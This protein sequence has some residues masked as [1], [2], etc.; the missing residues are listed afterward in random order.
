MGI[1]PTNLLHAMQALY[2]LS[3]APVDQRDRSRPGASDGQGAE[4]VAGPCSPSPL[5]FSSPRVV[6]NDCAP[7]IASTA[8]R[9]ALG[10]SLRPCRGTGTG[11]RVRAKGR[12]G[13]AEHGSDIEHAA[14]G[15]VLEAACAKRHARSGVPVLAGQRRTRFCRKVGKMP[16][17]ATLSGR[18]LGDAWSRRTGFTTERVYISVGPAS[19]HSREHSGVH[20]VAHLGAWLDDVGHVL[21]NHPT[22]PSFGRRQR[23]RVVAACTL[24][25]CLVSQRGSCPHAGGSPA[26]GRS[27]LRHHCERW[28]VPPWEL[29][30][31]LPPRG[32]AL[33]VS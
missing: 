7:C 28:R 24:K 10:G 9:P 33:D 1:E 25:R 15:G 26:A 5:P 11:T 18:Y 19:A 4:V 13:H 2:Q 32:P 12:Q 21:G 23:H 17:T 3:Y 29:G 8:R 16:S 20:R 22:G 30:R 6:I 31:R 27:R 14:R